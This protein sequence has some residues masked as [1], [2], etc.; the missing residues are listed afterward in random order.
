M[1]KLGSPPEGVG[2]VRDELMRDGQWVLQDYTGDSSG[3]GE[4]CVTHEC[5][6]EG[7]DGVHYL[8]RWCCCNNDTCP[9]CEVTVPTELVGMKYLVEWER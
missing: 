7:T 5:M 9:N 3:Y 8:S 1:L 4:A 6:R 2:G